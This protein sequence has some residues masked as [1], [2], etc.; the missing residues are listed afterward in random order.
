LAYRWDVALRLRDGI[1]LDQAIQRLRECAGR[2]GNVVGGSAGSDVTTHQNYYLSEVEAVDVQ[3]RNLFADPTVWGH[4]Y[5]D[6]YWAIR[7]AG[8]NTPRPMSMITGEAQLQAKH[9]E[10]L[11]ERLQRL[12]ARLIAA[13]GEITVLD[14]HVL[15]HFLPPQQ[16]DWREVV[17]QNSVRLVLPLRVVEELDMSKYR[18]RD[19]IADRARR[20]LS[21]LWS[22]LAPTAGSPAVLREGVTIEVPV[23]DGPRERTLDADEEILSECEL[24]RAVGKPVTLVTDDTGLSIRATARHIGIVPMPEKYL[25]RRPAPEPEADVPHSD[26]EGGVKRMDD[27][28]PD[29]AT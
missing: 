13:P 5:G 29:V 20:L 11:I 10:G 27:L 6:Q 28:A 8:P 18:E 25:R 4:L 19:V 7:V 21:Q 23:D 9:L 26:D 15:L 2:I 16:I 14:T 22:L 12:Q 24:L 17:S 3:L 1:V